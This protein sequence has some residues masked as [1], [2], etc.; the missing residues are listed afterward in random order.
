MQPLDIS[1][2][3]IEN[4]PIFKEKIL[5]RKDSSVASLINQLNNSDWV[6]KGLQYLPK[7]IKEVIKCPFCQEK[8]IT[9]I[10]IKSM[11]KYFDQ[12]YKQKIHMISEFLN[13]YE[14]MKQDVDKFKKNN[15]PSEYKNEFEK[16]IL[17]LIDILNQN[18]KK[19]EYKKNNPSEVIILKKSDYY[20]D[21]LNKFIQ[22]INEKINQHN[23]KIQQ[24]QQ[25]KNRIKNIF[26]SN[27]EIR[28]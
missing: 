16:H 5:G 8:T 11:H 26:W 10:F 17:N 25:E 2:N 28:I 27:Y 12:S 23:I 15:I 13:Q 9:E 1:S 3:E 14:S 6:K 18:I 7:D 24:A 19:I 21:E 4:N 20:L 22:T